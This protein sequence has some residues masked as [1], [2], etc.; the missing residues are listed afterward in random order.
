M[1]KKCEFINEV[2]NLYVFFRNQFYLLQSNPPPTQYTYANVFF[3]LQ[4]IPNSSF[5]GWPS[6]RCQIRRI[7]WLWND[8]DR[9]FGQIVT[10]KLSVFGTNRDHHAIDTKHLSKQYQQGF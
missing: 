6:K 4:N 8:M 1:S 10:N 2:K 3:N 5:P 7:R 9:I